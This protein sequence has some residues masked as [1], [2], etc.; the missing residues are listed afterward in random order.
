[1]QYISYSA[2]KSFKNSI[3]FPLKDVHFLSLIPHF[4]LRY[5]NKFSLLLIR[6]EHKNTKMLKIEKIK[7]LFSYFFD[8]Y[9]IMVKNII[10]IIFG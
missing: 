5:L 8:P 7:E 6:R 3:I 10:Y 1:M 2:I 4:E 9:L